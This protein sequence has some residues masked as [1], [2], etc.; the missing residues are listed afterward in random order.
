MQAKYILLFRAILLEVL[1][2]QVVYAPDA[3]NSN[4]LLWAL[5]ALYGSAAGAFYWLGRRQVLGEAA[6]AWSF[7]LD[8]ALTSAILYLTQG[9]SGDVFLAYFLVILSSCFLDS[10]RL[11]FVVGGVA[12]AVYAGLAFPGL[13]EA[14]S[15]RYML[16]LSL[17]LVTSFFSTTVADHARRLETQLTKRYEERLAWMQRLSG[18]GQALAKVLHEVKTPLGT[19]GLSLDSLKQLIKEGKRVD[20]AKRL[21]A[22]EAE[23]DKASAVIAD[24]LDYAK[25]AELA[26]KPVRVKD[27]VRRAMDTVRVHLK[28]RNI[29]LELRLEAPGEILGSERHLAQVATNLLMNAI[30]AMPLG[31]TLT[32]SLREEGGK[33]LLTVADNGLGFEPEA[34]AKVF[35]PFAASQDE[36]AG[37]GLGLSIARWIVLKHGGEIALESPGARRGAVARVELP[38]RKS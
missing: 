14:L 37:H 8:I 29:R 25:P 23:V 17:L 35:E 31:G 5:F 12:C 11:S 18:V 27:A 19:I 38:L 20:V 33:A 2:L 30:N 36:G 28:H 6:H 15:P 13:E 7:M 26:L 4:A 10:I 34:L 1:F 32:V 16:R 21:A 22:M 9:L 3:E 24:Y